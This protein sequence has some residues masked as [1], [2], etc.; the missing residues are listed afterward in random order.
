MSEKNNDRWIRKYL[1]IKRTFCRHC[2]SKCTRDHKLYYIEEFLKII[3][4]WEIS[5]D[6]HNQDN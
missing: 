6:Y 2:L 1:I 3:E 4:D 5:D